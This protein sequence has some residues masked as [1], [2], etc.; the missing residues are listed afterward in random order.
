MGRIRAGMIAGATGTL[1]LEAATYGDMLLRGRAPSSIPAE[2]AAKLAGRTGVSLGRDPARMGHRHEALG[3]LLGY[4]T[5]IGIGVAYAL[6]EPASRHAP[7][8]AVAAALGLGAMAAAD[9]P[10]IRTGLTDPKRWGLTGWMSDLVPHLA[11]GAA[12]V[13]AYHAL[14]RNPGSTGPQA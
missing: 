9:L 10:I 13:T 4:A 6:I 8:R 3:A 5:G 11:Y 14:R 1:A 2:A 7:Q 12:T